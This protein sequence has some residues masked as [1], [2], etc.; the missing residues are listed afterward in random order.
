MASILTRCGRRS[1]AQGAARQAARWACCSTDLLQNLKT[2]RWR[3]SSQQPMRSPMA[4]GFSVPIATNAIP[5]AI[6]EIIARGPDYSWVGNLPNSYQQGRDFAYQNRNRDLFQEGIP[7]DANGAID[8]NRVG[9]Q[10]M[11]AGGSQ[12]VPTASGLA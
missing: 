7:K 12:A 3:K 4:D 8:W 2:T 10:L 9:E 1:C 6:N 5:S 11:R